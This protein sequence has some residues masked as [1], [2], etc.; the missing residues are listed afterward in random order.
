[1]ND[2]DLR[3][4]TIICFVFLYLEL[5]CNSII[6]LQY[7]VS[8]SIALFYNYEHRLV[9]YTSPEISKP[10]H[11]IHTIYSLRCYIRITLS[12][13]CIV[14]FWFELPPLYIVGQQNLVALHCNV[15]GFCR[16]VVFLCTVLQCT[17]ILTNPSW[18]ALKATPIRNN[19]STLSVCFSL[20][21][22][23]SKYDIYFYRY[24]VNMLNLLV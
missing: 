19:G 7:T 6:A 4:Q 9:L 21:L 24:A 17:A 23:K 16:M 18:L 12:F 14:L 15:T 13:F 5:V 2:K 20:L 3:L 1:M 8:S 10:T 11:A 22:C